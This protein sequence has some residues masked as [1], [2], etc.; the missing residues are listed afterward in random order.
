MVEPYDVGVQS[1]HNCNCALVQDVHC[2]GKGTTVWSADNITLQY[3]QPQEISFTDTQPDCYSGPTDVCLLTYE[4][5]TTQT[6]GSNVTIA[7]HLN[8]QSMGASIHSQIGGHNVTEDFDLTQVPYQAYNQGGLNT[9]TFTSFSWV[10][11]QINNL[12]IIRAYSMWNLYPYNQTVP[13]QEG[14]NCTGDH[15]IGA[16]GNLDHTRQDYPCNYASIGDRMSYVHYGANKDV[17]TIS[18]GSS[19]SWKFQHPLDGGANN[20]IGPYICLFN[21]NNV[22]RDFDLNTDLHY[23][24]KLNGHAIADYYHGGITGFASQFPAVDLAKS[25]YYFDS[26]GAWNIVELYNDGTVDLHIDNGDLGGVDIYRFYKVSNIC[27]DRFDNESITSN[28]W[29][30]VKNGGSV[31][32]VNGQLQVT[33]DSGTGWRQAGLVTRYAYDTHAFYPGSIKQGFEA[34]IDVK[35]INGLKEM[36]LLV[37]G[38]KTTQEPYSLNNWYR[39]LKNNDNST[40]VVQNRLN[41]GTASNK[42]TIPWTSQTGKLKIKV[43]TGSIAF[44][45]NDQLRYAEPFAL[46]SNNC[47]IYAYTSS[48][49]NGTGTFDDFKIYPSQVFMEEFNSENPDDWD[50]DSGNWEIVDNKLRSTT[51]GSHIH[52]PEQFATNRHVRADIKTLTAGPNDEDV[53]WLIAKAV[54]GNNMIFGRILKNGMVQLGL[55]YGGTPTYW[56]PQTNPQIDPL[57]QHSMAISIIGENAKLWVD[58]TLYVDANNSHFDDIQEGYIGLYTCGSTGSFDSIAV[59]NAT[60]YYTINATADQGGS[61]SPSG[62]TQALESA[63]K[64]FTITKD[65]GY[66]AQVYV[67]GINQGNITNYT[68]NNVTANHTISALFIPPLTITS[69]AGSGGWISPSGSVSVSWGANKSFNIGANTCYAI[70]DVL[71]DDVSQGAISYYAFT[72]VQANHTISASF[73]PI[74]YTIIASAG[75]GGSINPSGYVGVNCGTNKTFNIQANSGYH[76]A[77]VLVD[78]V[79]QGAISNYTFTN[80]QANHT[81]SA[82]FASMFTIMAG[83]SGGSGSIT[84]SG[85][86]CVMP[87]A[88]QNFSIAPSAGYAISNVKVDNVSQGAISS[89]TFTNVQAN[90]VIQAYFTP[91][92]FYIGFD[93]WTF[94]IDQQWHQVNVQFTVDGMPGTTPIGGPLTAGYHTVT[95]PSS[96]GVGTIVGLDHAHDGTH[97]YYYSN[98]ATVYIGST[99]SITASYHY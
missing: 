61:I 9:I 13:P 54:D 24:I 64:S 94:Y 63:N 31:E 41:G 16:N 7:K 6:S 49:Q 8:G 81:I 85:Y 40:I 29:D 57:Q 3:N 65:L 38:E 53:A 71:V 78:S 42:L 75:S 28:L 55:H 20:H 37:S 68:F 58:G 83:V 33:V 56:Q 10:P 4:I 91:Q 12:R 5:A 90:H 51:N 19:Q 92:Q 36:D 99:G 70:T 72:N 93:A 21:F 59:L 46:P 73:T 62:S 30:P 14:A 89:Y 27:Q 86:V 80:V 98:S 47:Y 39:I 11:V 44:Y 25:Q 45:E 26:P 74:Q 97:D 79:S 82:S 22:W 1:G 43:S 77:D 35:S 76:I 95:F 50:I 66:I 60:N 18:P 84:P 96:I 2:G 32:N 23:I 67:D 88:N 52:Y 87:G 69:S 34:E 17:D 15:T 48:D